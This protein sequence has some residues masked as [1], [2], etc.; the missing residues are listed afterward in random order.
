MTLTWTNGR[1]EGKNG[2]GSGCLNAYVCVPLNSFFSGIKS[3]LFV[4]AD[5]M[6]SILRG[7]HINVENIEKNNNKSNNR[8]LIE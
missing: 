5:N 8:S 6:V 7:L 3:L 2:K 4:S 1:G